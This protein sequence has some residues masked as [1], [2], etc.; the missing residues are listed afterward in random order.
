MMGIASKD[1]QLVRDTQ[2]L[3][4]GPLPPEVTPLAEEMTLAWQAGARKPDDVYTC[5]KKMRPTTPKASWKA[6]DS[7]CSEDSFLFPGCFSCSL[8]SCQ[9]YRNVGGSLMY[10]HKSST[11]P[12]P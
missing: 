3:S 5:R 7:G 2:D 8:T 9:L 11:R 6:Y 12:G 4:Q 1:N 10:C